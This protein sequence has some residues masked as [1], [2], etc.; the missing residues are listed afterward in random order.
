MYFWYAENI[1]ARETK[2]KYLPFSTTTKVYLSEILNFSTIFYILIGGVIGVIV[3]LLG[4]ANNKIKSR[5]KK[6]VEIN[7]NENEKGDM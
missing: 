2:P 4:L 1:F 7:N 3:Y 5:K 6:D